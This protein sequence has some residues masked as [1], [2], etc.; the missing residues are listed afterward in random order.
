[1]HTSHELNYPWNNE[2][3]NL[4]KYGQI[5]RRGRNE[6]MA[7]IFEW[8]YYFSQN[9]HTTRAFHYDARE[10][11]FAFFQFRITAAC[12]HKFLTYG[13]VREGGNEFGE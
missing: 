10:K 1:M 2:C 4:I 13:F 11:W 6:Q 7:R 12:I 3:D 5:E 9:S 8:N